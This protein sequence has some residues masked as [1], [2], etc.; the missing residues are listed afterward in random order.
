MSNGA[1]EQCRSMK[2]GKRVRF[3]RKHAVEWRNCF[4]IRRKVETDVAFV[5]QGRRIIGS[6]FE[7][8][9]NHLESVG[10]QA[11]LLQYLGRCR[12][13]TFIGWVFVQGVP[14]GALCS[15]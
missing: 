9:F 5:E 8:F 6:E 13:Q 14:D 10:E 1:V 11:V 7:L 3:K 12:N 2:F 4:V 15:F